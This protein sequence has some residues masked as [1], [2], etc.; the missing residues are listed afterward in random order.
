MHFKSDNRRTR[1]IA[2]LGPATNNPTTIVRMIRAGT[3]VF[4]L[5]F[6]HGDH[7]GHRLTLD[8]IR[9]A[10][11]KLKRHPGILADLQGPKIRTGRCADDRPI[12]LRAGAT[13]TLTGERRICTDQI[14]SI[15]YPGLIAALKKEQRVFLNDGAVEL[16]IRKTADRRRQVVT[17]VV[18]P[19]SYSSHKGVNVPDLQLKMPVLSKK[20]LHDLEFITRAGIPIIA[21]SFVR[22]G[23]DVTALRRHLL[24]KNRDALII[25]KIE[26]PE[27]VDRID[28]ILTVSDGIMVAR[29]DLGIEL[30]LQELPIVQKDLIAAATARERIVIVAT[31]MMESMINNP[32]PTRAESND[33]ANAILEGADA[34]MLSGETAVGSYPVETVSMMHR[35]ALACERSAYFPIGPLDHTVMEPTMAHALC[36]AAARAS[37]DLDDAPVVVFTRSGQTART[38]SKL[39]P[40]APILACT[41]SPMVASALSLT[42]NVQSFLQPEE[43]DHWSM[44]KLAIEML[45]RRKVIRRGEIILTLSGTAM[46][47]GATNQLRVLRAGQYQE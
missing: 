19:G 5:N 12:S 7:P 31:Q 24:R 47:A 1:I 14:I 10:S 46:T 23:A 18:R 6:S 32:S 38:L 41:S 27:A 29:G 26:K 22:R 45:L 4:R 35:I 36:E 11:E 39:R 40:S 21:L 33:V 28:E 2:T 37:A 30:S 13:V 3:D 34:V 42:W 43:H 44:Q 25:A 17:E 20:D 16:W 15:D 8:N 9:T